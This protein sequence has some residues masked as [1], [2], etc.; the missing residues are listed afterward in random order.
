MVSK[1]LNLYLIC[2]LFFLREEIDSL[3][4]EIAEI[5]AEMEKI[6]T[7]AEVRDIPYTPAEVRDMLY[8]LAEIRD[9]MAS[10][11]ELRDLL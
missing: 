2:P 5:Q 4:K 3:K 11:A 9:K 8:T 10:P 7:P 1:P 6:A